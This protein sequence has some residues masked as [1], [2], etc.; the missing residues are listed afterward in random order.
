MPRSQIINQRKV[1]FLNPVNPRTEVEYATDKYG[2]YTGEVLPIRDESN[3]ELAFAMLNVSPY[4]SGLVAVRGALE[5]APFGEYTVYDRTMH[6]SDTNCPVQVGAVCWI[7]ADHD[8]G[9]PADYRVTKRSKSLHELVYA[10][11]QFVGEGEAG[12]GG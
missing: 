8:E 3:G 2:N 11:R 7:E 9:E 12:Y 6:T 4:A 10:I 1:Y 5:G